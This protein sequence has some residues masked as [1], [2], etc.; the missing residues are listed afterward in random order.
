MLLRLD[1]SRLSAV[2]SCSLSRRNLTECVSVAGGNWSLQM[3]HRND[4]FSAEQ[5]NTRGNTLCFG[6]PHFGAPVTFSAGL[7]VILKTNESSSCV[8]VTCSLSFRVRCVLHITDS[9][10]QQEERVVCR[11]LGGELQLQTDE[12]LQERREQQEVYR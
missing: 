11:V 1:P 10:E 12:L 7:I 3:F 2:C 4:D 9:G 8:L 5:I 6:F